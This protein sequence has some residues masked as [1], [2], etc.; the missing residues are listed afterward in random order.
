[1][2]GIDITIEY[3]LINFSQWQSVK[4]LPEEYFDLEPDEKIEWD[5]VPWHNHA[6]DYLDIELSLVEFTKITLK[7]NN[8]SILS[9]HG[10]I[11]D[12]EDGSQSEQIIYTN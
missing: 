6:I 12:N 1:M 7:E 11:T 3:K 4:F 9:Y 2:S 5:C 8:L 10:L